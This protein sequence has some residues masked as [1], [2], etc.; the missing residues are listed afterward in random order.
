MVKGR[1]PSHF[2]LKK[3]KDALERDYL[4]C[5]LML[6]EA[7]KQV[8]VLQKERASLALQISEYRKMSEKTRQDF[9]VLEK[10][11]DDWKRSREVMIDCLD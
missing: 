8:N 4:G 5:N 3:E 7:Q 2:D 1:W 10:Q 6:D 11:R 9:I